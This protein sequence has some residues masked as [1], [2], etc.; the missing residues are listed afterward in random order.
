M[1]QEAAWLISKTEAGRLVLEARRQWTIQHAREVDA[2]LERLPPAPPKSVRVDLSGL[3]A[4]DTAGAWLIHRTLK[5]LR[6]AGGAVELIGASADGRQLLDQ[7]AA[8]DQACPE[9]PQERQGIGDKI[10]RVGEVAAFIGRDARLFVGFVGLTVETLLRVA[11][12]PWRFRATSFIATLEATGLNAMPIVGLISFLVGVVLAYQGAMQL[13]TFGAEIFVVDLVAISVLREI[14][15][16]LTAIV[17]A[18]RSGSAF[19]AQIGSMKV[20][21]EIDAMRVLG[22]DPIEVLVVPRVVALVVALPLL[23]FLSDM[24]GLFGGALQAWGDL[25][26]SPAVF[27]RRVQE[28]VAL[29]HFWVGMIKAPVFAFMIAVVGCYQG[30][31]VRNTADSVGRLTTR[32]V[33]QS[34][35]MVIVADALFSILFARLNL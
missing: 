8:A 28:D 11:L 34:I 19:T 33:V 13:R 31:R 18:G 1:Q 12:K 2:E 30:M 15:I 21:E 35:F 24:L 14:G 16:L 22:L 29:G 26:I 5:R 6:D 3:E 23:C 9:L 32:S 7:V 27:I 10:A 4:L 17:V 20:A 25:D